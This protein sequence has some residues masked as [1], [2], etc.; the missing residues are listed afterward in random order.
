MVIGGVTARPGP[1]A[2][3]GPFLRLPSPPVAER[4]RRAEEGEWRRPELGEQVGRETET[5]VAPDERG[6]AGNRGRVREV[7]SEKRPGG[8]LC[9]RSPPRLSG[10]GGRSVVSSAAGAGGSV[11][12][13]AAVA[14]GL[15][16]PQRL[17][18]GGG[19]SAGAGV[20]RFPV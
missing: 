13:S 19:V 5:R 1:A 9:P 18:R 20:L 3:A 11:V 2:A 12:S 16:S 4:R 6:A 7:P 17:G 8:G 14:G 10:W 15:S